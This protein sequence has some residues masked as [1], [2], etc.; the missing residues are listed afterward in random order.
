VWDAFEI[1]MKFQDYAWVRNMDAVY[2][3]LLMSLAGLVGVSLL[4]A[5]PPEER[6]KPFFA[7]AVEEAVG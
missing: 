6:W 7:E 4:S 2:P 5:P 1:Q 3:A